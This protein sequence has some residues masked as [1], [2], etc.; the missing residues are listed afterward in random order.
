MPEY[1]NYLESLDPVVGA[2]SGDEIIGASK[3]G[4]AVSLTAQQIADLGGGGGA[5]DS[6]NG[7][8]GVVV[9]D[10]TDVGADPAGTAAALLTGTISDSDT[11]HAPTGNAVF[12]AL[13][14]KANLESPTFTG[15]PVA[16]TAATTT[17]TT[18]VATTAFVQ[19]EIAAKTVGVQDL[20][21]PAQA[22]WP[23]VTSGCS[24]LTQYEMT[25]SLLNL[26]GLEFSSSVQQFAQMDVPLPRK[27]NNGTVTVV[28]H[29]KPLASG[30]GDVR[31]GIQLAS[32]RNDD[33]LTAAFG[34]EVAVT[35]TFIAT[36]DLHITSASAA[37]T[38]SGTVADGNLMA[39]QINR[40]PTNGSDTLTV[41]AIL[42][43][44]IVR[45]TTDNAIDS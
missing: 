1:S 30:S 4:G 32:Y 41:N 45:I 7:Q 9:L 13:A 39:L 34:T 18:Q 35:D 23:R 3:D 10:A 15:T 11:T 6:V 26:Q 24:V 42:I 22:M 19:Q 2:L 28:I 37:I 38:P 17:N 21:I 25:T 33:A 40:D 44:V 27:Y 20:P 29:W 8:T 12:D 31:W 36:D 43:A 5:V 14:L 16:P